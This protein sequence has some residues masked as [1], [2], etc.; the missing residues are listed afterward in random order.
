MKGMPAVGRFSLHFI[1]KDSNGNILRNTPYKI[2]DGNSLIRG[3]TNRKGKTQTIYSDSPDNL[4][5][6][7]DWDYFFKKPK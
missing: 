4:V 5:C 6:E 1:L 3:I 2:S 7:E